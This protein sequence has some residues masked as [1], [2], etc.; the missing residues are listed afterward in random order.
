MTG[1]GIDRIGFYTPRYYL[2]LATLAAAR[3]LSVEKYHR[4]LGQYQMAML[5][6]S[7]DIVTMAANAAL[8]VLK[9]GEKEAIDTVLFATESGIDHSKSAG[10]FL[11]RLLELPASCRVVELKQAC[12][13]GTAALQLAVSM[14]AQ[15]PSRKILV[16][17]SDSA[18]YGFHTTGE[19]SQGGGAIAM[20]I[21]HEPRLLVI[22]PGAAYRTQDVMDFWRPNYAEVPF[23]DGKYSINLYLD[24]LKETWRSYC[25]QTNRTFTDHAYFCY[26]NS[27]PRLVEKAHKILAETSGVELDEQAIYK[28]VEPSLHYSRFVGNC[29]T[30]ALYI[31]LVSLLD[32]VSTDLSS[33]R[34]GF[35]SY[36]SGCVGEYFSGKIVPGYQ[37]VLDT[38]YN[39]QLIQNRVSLDYA[40]YEHFYSFPYPQDGSLCVL[41]N[42]CLVG[43]FRL[44]R[45]ENHKRIYEQVA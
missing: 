8:R 9:D 32:Q 16:I 39:R 31:G 33:Q 12:Y 42:D 45:I 40:T 15:Q 3:N 18:W 14:V 5:P 22:E 41:P 17:A 37:D 11:H 20:L 35:Y 26:H 25:A 4:G 1:I 44:V 34:I 43:N 24:L 19:S 38:T 27:V 7:E 30:A 23:V 28:A 29:Y 2:D 10:I 13:S 21:T 6:P 36:G